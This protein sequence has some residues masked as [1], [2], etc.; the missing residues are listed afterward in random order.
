MNNYPQAA[1][2]SV[3]NKNKC[4]S[5]GDSA[6]AP[7]LQGVKP[8]YWAIHSKTGVHIGLWPDKADA[9]EVL[10]EYEGGTITPLFK[11]APAPYPRAQALEEAA[12]LCDLSADASQDQ[13]N[14]E[15]YP[16][17]RDALRGEVVAAR[18]LAERIR[19]LSSK[20]VEDANLVA[21]ATELYEALEAAANSS[22]FQYMFSETRDK[23]NSALTKARGSTRPT[24]GSNHGE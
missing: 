5:D 22:G 16:V 13:L 24:G 12:K 8:D 19:A 20:P 15:Q 11:S 4:G 14:K 7:F 1:G 2:V 3:Q 6:A 9:D 10:R 17:V 18:V 21:A 23:I